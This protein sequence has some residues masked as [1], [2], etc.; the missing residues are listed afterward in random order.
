[1]I[2]H[3]F[4]GWSG[5]LIDTMNPANVTM[6]ADKNITANFKIKTYT[7]TAST[8]LNGSIS[9]SGISVVNYGDSIVY[10]INPDVGYHPIDVQIDSVSFGDLEDY[11]FTNVTSNH[12]ISASFLK[13]PPPISIE[14]NVGWSLVSVPHVMR[15]KSADVVFKDKL[16][17]MFGYNL[18]TN[19]YYMVYNLKCGEGY[20]VYYVLPATVIFDGYNPSLIRINAKTGWNIVGS[21]STTIEVSS[22]ILSDGSSIVG[23]AYRYKFSAKLYEETTVIYPGEAVWISVTKPCTITFP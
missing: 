20:W 11:T 3:D 17:D 15:N 8:G 2:S 14:T 10:T 7:I 19:N 5:D 23:S 21:R 12:T 6:D 18:M 13:N 4:I 1:V 9:P 16:S 22:L